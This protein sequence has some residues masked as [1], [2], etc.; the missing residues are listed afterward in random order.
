MPMAQ[1]I[2][3]QNQTR[4]P[5][6]PDADDQELLERYLARRDEAAFATLVQ[7][8]SGT[9]WSVCRRV[10]HQEQDAEDAFQAVFIILARKASLIR[11]REAVGSWL[12][13]VAYRTAMRARHSANRRRDR[14][15]QQPVPQAVESSCNEAAL[16][17]LQGILDE[18]VQRLWAKYREAFVLCALQGLSKAEAARLLGCTEGTVSSR[19]TRA[20]QLLQ[21]RLARRGIAITTALAAVALSPTIAS[22]AA[23][24]ALVHATIQGVLT[25]HGTAGLSPA[26]LTLA[27]GFIRALAGTQLKIG[28]GVVLAFLTLVAGQ[29]IPQGAEPVARD[30]ELYCDFR[31]SKPLPPFVKKVGVDAHTLIKPE[32]EGL[33]I[34]LPATRKRTDKAGVKL[35]HRLAGDFEITTGFEILHAD[36]PTGERG[37]GF[38]LYLTT[39]TALEEGL[40]LE[41]LTRAREGDLLLSFHMTTD[42]DRKQHYQHKTQPSSMRA[43]QLRITRIGEKVAFSITEGDGDEF[44]QLPLGQVFGTAVDAIQIAAHPGYDHN[45]VDVRIKDLRIRQLTPDE[46]RARARE[47]LTNA[48]LAPEGNAGQPAATRSRGWLLVG[49]LCFLLLTIASAVWLWL[50]RNR[51]AQDGSAPTHTTVAVQCSGCGKTLSAKPERAGKKAKCPRCG[52]VVVVPELL[53]D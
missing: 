4:P 6:N 37:V 14:D 12:Y 11:K 52:Q 27:D 33:R 35:A 53:E 47:L 26:A 48:P 1:M 45:V 22:A 49:L 19:V 17:E 15:R 50:C 13:G 39:A 43:G 41:R 30:D 40:G 25:G 42:K 44:R 34:T 10:L 20:R 51:R 8:H 24:P 29:A 3:A 28:F 9:V 46:S 7:R 38:S 21:K 16:R 31:G 23:P 32:D 18:Q 36:R 5:I 2:V